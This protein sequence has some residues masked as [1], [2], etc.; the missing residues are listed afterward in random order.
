VAVAQYPLLRQLT[1]ASVPL[2]WSGIAHRV[3]PE[4]V[5]VWQTLQSPEKPV[6]VHGV[7]V[8]VLDVV[9]HVSPAAT[10]HWLDEVQYR[11]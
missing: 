2:A 8:H 3:P 5:H 10:S 4:A 1:P 7:F 9:S 6:P 11:S